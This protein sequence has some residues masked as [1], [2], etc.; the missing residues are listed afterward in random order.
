MIKRIS[1]FMSKYFVFIAII[2]GISGYLLPS[3]FQ[4][5][6]P[7]TSILLGIT[8]FSMGLTTNLEDFKNIFKHPRS[9]LVGVICVFTVSPIVVFILTKIL[10]KIM[11]LHP[12]IALGLVLCAACPGGTTSNVFTMLAKGDT[13]LSI[14]MT[15]IETILAAIATPLIILIIYG[16]TTEVDAIGMMISVFQIV[17]IP[18]ALG[19]LFKTKFI[20]AANKLMDAVPMISI[21]SIILILGGVMAKN[22]PLLVETGMEAIIPAALFIPICTIAGYYVSK[23]FKASLAERKAIAI[24]VGFKNSNLGIALATA[25]FADMPLA[26]IPLAIIVVMTNI[27]GPL[28]SGFWAKLE[29]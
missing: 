21:G 17:V 19:L 29:E 7:Y 3:V 26:T 1:E 18:V 6:S 20:N 5:V 14:S 28:L 22:G 11:N 25:H 8:M 24:E 10:T 9:L 16:K 13:P 23:L 12:E 27:M 4:H 15:F 2:I